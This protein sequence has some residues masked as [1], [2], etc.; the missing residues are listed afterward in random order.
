MSF[1]IDGRMLM[2]RARP[3]ASSSRRAAAAARRR[4]PAL[5]PLE[6]RRLLTLLPMQIATGSDGHLW[7]TDYSDNE[8]GSVDPA[9]HIVTKI[10]T[11]TASSGPV[12]MA[13]GPDGKLWFTERNAAR[14]GSINPTTDHIDEYSLPGGGFEP[15][16][17][18]AGPDGKLWF[19]EGGSNQIG[20]IDPSTHHIDQYTIPTAGADPY[21]IA[22]GPDGK[23][24]FTERGGNR[25]GSIDPTTHHIDEY[26]VPTANAFPFSIAAGPDGRLWF[27]E[28]SA[29]RIGAIDPTTHQ[30]TEYPTPTA[31][32]I[33]TGIAAGP[34]GRLWFLEAEVSQIGSIDP[35][36]HAIVETPISVGNQA[37]P[38]G[39][40]AGPDGNFWYVENRSPNVDVF[41]P[42]LDLVASSGPP[43]VVTP[44]AA[45]GLTV[46]IFYQ[47]G[48]PDTAFDGDVTLALA[49]GAGGATLGGTITVTAHH[50]VATFSG[51][52]IGQPGT[53]RIVA[54]AG[55][56]STTV[57]APVT[58]DPPPTIVAEKVLFAGKGRHR[59]VVGY[60]L[61]FSSA[62]DPTRAASAAEYALTQGVRHG[63]QLVARAVAVQ[64]AYDARA[65]VVTLTLAGR[66]QFA[67][68]GKLV[69]SGTPPGGLTDASGVPLDGGGTGAV[70]DNGT[71][72]I[73]PK[74]KGISR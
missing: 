8:I 50:G 60:E 34:D 1:S 46:S 5:E 39:V 23:L 26:A 53:Y 29:S 64:A 4:R 65:H 33:P 48:R 61:D 31:G 2:G 66:P 38:D 52:T 20:S 54:S 70:G 49:P 73:A 11:P 15:L 36:T 44:G 12:G 69:V 10:T 32:S 9:T 3:P 72:V 30:I 7:F 18:T 27:T 13:V 42:P 63:R 25:I 6:S 71:F 51:L 62:M 74:G 37:S 14:I 56:Q 21:S 55:P 67:R 47:S 16:G 40:T 17:I 41:K 28:Y 59:R 68:G 24:W 45:F 57:T 35:A 19:A 22:A 43:G 58:V